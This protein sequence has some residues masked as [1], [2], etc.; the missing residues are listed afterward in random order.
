MARPDVLHPGP[1]AP[2]TDDAFGFT[3]GLH[4]NGSTIITIVSSVWLKQLGE[5]SVMWSRL[6]VDVSF[7]LEVR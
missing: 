2:G 6:Y 3:Y 4:H 1:P 5:E 7:A